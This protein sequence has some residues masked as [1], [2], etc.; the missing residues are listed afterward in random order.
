MKQLLIVLTFVFGLTACGGMP[1]SP[2]QTVF[3]TKSSYGLVLNAAAN[4]AELPTCSDVQKLPCADP[5]VVAQLQ[6]AEPGVRTTLDAAENAVR[7][8]GFGDSVVKSSVAAAQ[9]ALKAFT[10]ILQTYAAP[11]PGVPK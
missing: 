1:T 10:S 7:T 5:K 11:A 2:A 4:Y 6:K 8:P 9:A 3:E